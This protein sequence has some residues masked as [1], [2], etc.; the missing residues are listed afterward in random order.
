MAKHMPAKRARRANPR[1]DRNID[2]DYNNV[3]EF[4]KAQQREQYNTDLNI[5]PKRVELIPRN[6]S[7]EDYI[8]ALNDESKHIVF[9]MG[10]AGCGKTLLATLFAI[11]GLQAG[12]FKRIVITRPAVSVDEQHGFLPG[13][14]FSKMEPWVLP[15]LDVFK[16]H[17]SLKTITGMIESGT[18]EIA[19]LAYMRGRTFK[20]AIIIADEMQNSTVSQAK[21]VLTR[22]GEN[23]RI[24]MTGDLKQHDRGYEINGL[25]DFVT[26]LKKIGSHGIEVCEFHN[27]DVERHPIIEDVLRIYGDE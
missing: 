13:N 23:S 19:P 26:R 2:R 17:F 12:Q 24:I 8:D 3:Y 14:L 10:P 22:I 11:K 5:K 7:Q 6:I 27:E 18:I 16:E 9:A 1:E 15:I 20:D 21:M 25:G 4:K